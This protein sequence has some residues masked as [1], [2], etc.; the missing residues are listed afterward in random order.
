MF[1]L[2]IEQKGIFYEIEVFL[3]VQVD[4]DLLNWLEEIWQELAVELFH[5]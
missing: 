1:V 5:C 3:L 4:F 2:E